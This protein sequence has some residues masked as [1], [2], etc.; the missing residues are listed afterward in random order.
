MILDE[1]GFR[2]GSTQINASSNLST[3]SHIYTNYGL[4]SKTS[5]T[6]MLGSI[7][8]DFDQIETEVAEPA[9][10]RVVMPP[11]YFETQYHRKYS[12]V[13]DGDDDVVTRSDSLTLVNISSAKYILPNL[14]LF[15]YLCPQE[16]TWFLKHI[17]FAASSDIQ[18]IQTSN[19]S[20]FLSIQDNF[21][22]PDESVI[23]IKDIPLYCVTYR[24]K[25][26]KKTPTG[27][28]S[29]FISSRFN[30][31]TEDFTSDQL[32]RAMKRASEELKHLNNLFVSTEFVEHSD[33]FK[34]HMESLKLP[35]YS[36]VESFSTNQL[37]R[38]QLSLSESLLS[39]L[40]A[41]E[42][43]QYGYAPPMQYNR[44][45]L[46]FPEK[47]KVGDMITSG[48]MNRHQK[49]TKVEAFRAASETRRGL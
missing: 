47:V 40:S 2:F 32:T 19:M 34:K 33:V 44:I 1:T 49:E 42:A 11:K 10:R 14:D 6:E 8:V 29:E 24:V 7:R 27:N 35:S 25:D 41:R 20:D 4:T 39:I 17:A 38:L 21:R 30:L 46:S 3:G 45:R 13:E 5:S 23:D 43:Q 9:F 22:I 37:Q 36:D 26:A 28:G 48:F 31:P 12:I 18:S 15:L 16:L